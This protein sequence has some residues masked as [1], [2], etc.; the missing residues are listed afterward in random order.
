MSAFPTALHL[1]AWVSSQLEP[2]SSPPRTHLVSRHVALSVISSFSYLSGLGFPITK[3]MAGK[4]H[5]LWSRSPC[6]GGVLSAEPDVQ[7]PSL[8]MLSSNEGCLGTWAEVLVCMVYSALRCCLHC[9]RQ[10]FHPSDGLWLFVPAGFGY[11]ALWCN[12]LW[13]LKSFLLLIISQQLQ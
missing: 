13:I 10:R 3:A 8:E 2:Y 11:L 4:G 1:R 9:H 6:G 5:A 7:P 12:S